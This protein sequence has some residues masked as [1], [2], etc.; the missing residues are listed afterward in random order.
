[1]PVTRE[2]APWRTYL[3]IDP[4]TGPS[5]HALGTIFYVGLRHELPQPVDLREATAPESL[6]EGETKARE[7]LEHLN[8]EGGRVI[9]EVVPEQGWSSADSGHPLNAPGSMASATH[10][11]S[12][13]PPGITPRP[14][15]PSATSSSGSGPPSLRALATAFGAVLPP[16]TARFSSKI[17][18]SSRTGN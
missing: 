1:M 14:V 13:N 7:R 16:I 2:A 8:R 5:N 10:T 12:T 15:L 4:T 11:P 9:V 3:L 17:N 6:P 18:C